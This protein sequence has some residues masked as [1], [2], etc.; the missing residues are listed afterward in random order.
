MLS[1]KLLKMDYVIQLDV[2]EDVIVERLSGRFSC[3]KCSAV[4]HDSYKKP[5]ENDKCDKCGAREFARRSDDNPETVRSRLEAYH[6][7]TRPILP[8]YRDKGVL[9]SVD[10]MV[11]MEEVFNQIKKIITGGQ[12]KFAVM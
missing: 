9:Q 12:S 3:S 6:K 1:D 4:Y 8:F 7:K 2:D 5:K 11:T 10:G